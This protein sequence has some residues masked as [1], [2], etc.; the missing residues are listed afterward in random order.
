V[1]RKPL[2]VAAVQPESV[3][4]SRDVLGKALDLA[5]RAVERGAEVVCLPEH[6]IPGRLPNLE[7]AIPSFAE[8]AKTSGVYVIPGADFSNHGGSVEVQSAVLGPSGEIGRQ[9][10]THLFRRENKWASP[11]DSFATFDLG[12]VRAGITIC[13]DL[14]Y[15][16]VARILTLK[17]AEIIF[18]P[19]MITKTGYGPWELYATT[20]ALENRV[21]IV[22]PNA[23]RPPNYQGGSLI[24]GFH[25]DEKEGIVEP[26]VLARAGKKPSL[27]LADVDLDQIRK[28]REERLR[29][30]RPELYS[31]ILQK[32]PPPIR[33]TTG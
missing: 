30:R 25:T 12:G 2:R 1:T 29:V 5:K 18:A 11:G 8:L 16:E 14:V 32:G 7:D 22:T 13:H 20:R 21:P 23:I 28:Y 17:G 15:P 27:V 33:R 19:A 4:T 26:K 24:V 3:G 10:K 9:A 6:W 31:E